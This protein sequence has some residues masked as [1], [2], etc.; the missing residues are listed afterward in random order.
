MDG[1]LA[2]NP[3][4]VLSLA[5]HMPQES[6]PDISVVVPVLNSESTLRDL[7]A[8]TSA[9]LSGM[10][11]DFEIIFVDDGS[12]D[13]SWRVIRELKASSSGRVRG[14]KL[15]RN[16]GQQAATVC[17]LQQASGRW[18]VTLDDDLQT[19]PEEIPKLWNIAADE[20]SDVIYGICPAQNH[21]FMHRVGSY[22][23][24]VLVRR[25]APSVPSASSFRLIR[26]EILESFQHSSGA[27]LF[28]DPA[29]AWFTSDMATVEV[30]HEKRLNGRSSYSLAKLAHMAITI[31][32]I[33]S[34]LPLQFMIWFGLFSAILSFCI[35]I[36]YLIIKLTSNV[37]P[38]FSAL[39][40]MMTFAFGV[41]LLSLGILGIYISK[42][43]NMSTGQPSFTVRSQI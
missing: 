17:G 37:P 6:R 12:V 35:G 14:L 25:M 21:G 9:V 43:Y 5:T 1:T 7:F 24:R 31:L 26:R 8:R 16:S 23:F 13:S 34:T 29:L 40:V 27:W 41:I 42:I 11:L 3:Q 20:T 32:V 30:R 22:L 36:Y 4:T 39:I 19:P 18:V 33:Y 15:A 2:V 10:D 38:G 28:L